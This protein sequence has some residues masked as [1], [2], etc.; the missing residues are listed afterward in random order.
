M[1]SGSLG[2]RRRE[3]GADLCILC[4]G[5]AWTIIYHAKQQI[6]L[7][8][9]ALDTQAQ[10]TRLLQSMDNAVFDNRLKEQLWHTAAAQLYRKH[11]VIGQ[12][13]AVAHLLEGQIILHIADVHSKLCRVST[14]TNTIAHQAGKG[15]NH[16]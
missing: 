10:F 7:L 16:L 15:N 8:R 13:I 1:C 2:R 6:S 11:D 9:T 4:R 5:H 14:R 3:H 12:P